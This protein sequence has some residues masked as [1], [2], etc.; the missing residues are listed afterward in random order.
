MLRSGLMNGAQ[1]AC[2]GSEPSLEPPQHRSGKEV[3]QAECGV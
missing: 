2:L 1:T 3:L